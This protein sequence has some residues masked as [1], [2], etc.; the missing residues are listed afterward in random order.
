MV[1]CCDCK[2][3]IKRSGVWY[4]RASLDYLV[5]EYDVFKDDISCGGFKKRS[6]YQKKFK[7][8]G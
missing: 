6:W 7:K 5:P 1:K 3:L 2:D 8:R 4:C